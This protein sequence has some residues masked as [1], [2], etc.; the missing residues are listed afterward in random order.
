MSPKLQQ[1]DAG[2]APIRND[3]ESFR[4]TRRRFFAALETE[5]ALYNLETAWMESPRHE[6]ARE[7][8]DCRES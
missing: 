5:S 7:P 3:F 1:R 8:L 4:E 6:Q 2:A